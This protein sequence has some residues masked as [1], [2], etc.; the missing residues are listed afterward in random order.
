MDP[1]LGFDGGVLE[2]STD[3]GNT[4]QDILAAGGTFEMA[5]TTAQL[6]LIGVARL[7][8]VKPGAAIRKASLR[9]WWTSRRWVASTLDFAGG[10]PVTRGLKR[11]LAR[12]HCQSH[13]L[14]STA[15]F[16][17][18][19]RKAQRNLLGDAPLYLLLLRELASRFPA[20][21][22]T[23]CPSAAQLTLN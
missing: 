20:F 17:D 5:A 3:G 21:P 19:Y 23:N 18:A 8:V 1:N 22:P 9:V 10:W 11:R 12:G 14:P 7:Q 4:F 16:T 15:V 6:A 13:L 2:V